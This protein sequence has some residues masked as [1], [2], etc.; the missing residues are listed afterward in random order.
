M[1]KQWQFSPFQ[2]GKSKNTIDSI[3]MIS[4]DIIRHLTVEV[5]V[6]F[7]FRQ[8][9]MDSLNTAVVATTVR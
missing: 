9:A 3:P 5:A 6:L 1:Q 8:E 7:A 2:A 4:L